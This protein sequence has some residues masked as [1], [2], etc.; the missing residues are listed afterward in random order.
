MKPHFSVFSNVSRGLL[1]KASWAHEDMVE[2]QHTATRPRLRRNRQSIDTI[3]SI[4]T[5]TMSYPSTSAPEE[6][7][8]A[9]FTSLHLVATI[10]KSTDDVKYDFQ[11]MRQYTEQI[12]KVL[13]SM[14]KELEATPVL[15]LRSNGIHFRAQWFI[16]AVVSR[17]TQWLTV[18]G[19][20]TAHSSGSFFPPGHLY[21]DDEITRAIE[22]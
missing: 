1:S 16:Q 21:R 4:R 6:L 11:L 20:A 10:Q 8:V 15:G 14:S 17:P 22:G 12:L 19:Y 3:L 13:R 9:T 7:S 18:L 5:T 2:R